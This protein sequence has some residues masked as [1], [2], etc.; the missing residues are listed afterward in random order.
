MGITGS[1]ECSCCAGQDND[2]NDKPVIQIKV[3]PVHWSGGK[4][5]ETISSCSED[6]E[7]VGE[8]IDSLVAHRAAASPLAPMGT[9]RVLQAAAEAAA[10]AAWP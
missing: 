9:R 7:E 3:T 8:Q 10:V 1:M 6:V 4:D 5:G 2:N